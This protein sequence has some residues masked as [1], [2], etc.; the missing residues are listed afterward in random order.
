MDNQECVV[1]IFRRQVAHGA[2]KASAGNG[3]HPGPR[4]RNCLLCTCSRVEETILVTPFLPWWVAPTGATPAFPCTAEDRA[5]RFGQLEMRP[6]ERDF[7]AT[8][9]TKT[10]TASEARCPELET[11]S[12]LSTGTI[13]SPC[14]MK[15]ALN[16]ICNCTTCHRLGAKK[17]PP[18]T[19]YASSVSC[20]HSPPAAAAGCVVGGCRLPVNGFALT[21]VCQVSSDRP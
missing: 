10:R 9:I 13:R 4:V 12:R 15:M 21:S 2:E 3:N 20:Q 14:V 18:L 8:G 5:V 16:V 17:V 7:Q 1:R 19:P 11:G 6:V